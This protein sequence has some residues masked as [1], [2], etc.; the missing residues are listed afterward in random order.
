MKGKLNE[1]TVGMIVGAFLGLWHLAWSVL[2]S[3]GLA[4]EL[5]DWVFDIHMLGNP[6]V[7][8]PFDM[9]K[10]VTLVLFTAAV[11][12]VAGWVFSFIWNMAVRK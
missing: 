10:A 1:N 2:V 7:V 3:A 8:M 6:L 11:G 9:T 4:Q 12:Y 5:L